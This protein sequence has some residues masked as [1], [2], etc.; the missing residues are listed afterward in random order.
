M[1]MVR[2]A[3]EMKNSSFDRKAAIPVT[4]ISRQS[5]SI[6]GWPAKRAQPVVKRSK[7]ACIVFSLPFE[8]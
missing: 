4:L 2:L 7:K 5:I 8:A 1:L 6:A 3:P